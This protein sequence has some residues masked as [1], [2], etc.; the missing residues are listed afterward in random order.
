MFVTVC[1]LTDAGA[2]RENNEDAL[3]VVELSTF[4]PVELSERRQLIDVGPAGLLAVVSDGMGGEQ[5]GEVASALTIEA[6]RDSLA[7]AGQVGDAETRLRQSV[8]H[9]NERVRQA[10]RQTGR[11]GMG[12]TAIAFLTD[13][14]HLWTAEVGDS[15]AYLFREGRLLQISKDQTYIQALIE[16]GVT[17]PALLGASKAKNVILQAVGKQ[18]DISVAQ[19]RVALRHGDVVLLCSD[20]L[21][22][23][24]P[25]EEIEAVLGSCLPDAASLLV[26]I[27]NERGGKD[28]ITVLL[29][30]MTDES[31]PP[32]TPE[33]SVS[34]TCVVLHPYALFGGAAPSSAPSPL[35]DDDEHY[36]DRD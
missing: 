9:A 26:A 23:L 15:R 8:T 6:M 34:D 17:D 24:V 20:G 29:T 32:P 18:A 19:T 14:T 33:E 4:E 31:L 28:N 30:V 2:V 36:D 10:A 5:A 22:G 7:A 12:A 1:G 25:D 16:R 13:G 35:G 3:A 21:H 11:G 27:A